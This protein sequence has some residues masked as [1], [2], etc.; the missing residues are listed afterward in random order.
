MELAGVQTG[1]PNRKVQ[2]RFGEMTAAD[3]QCRVHCSA[4]HWHSAEGDQADTLGHRPEAV[5]RG[6]FDGEDGDA[7]GMAAS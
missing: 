7:D 4:G 3:S 1:E 2:S 5:R 6:I